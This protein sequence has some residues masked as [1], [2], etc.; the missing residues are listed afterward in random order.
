MEKGS[1]PIDLTNV[2]IAS[3]KHH[4]AC[5]NEDDKVIALPLTI[6]HRSHVYDD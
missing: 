3:E 2:D 1:W 5:K 6:G 4:L